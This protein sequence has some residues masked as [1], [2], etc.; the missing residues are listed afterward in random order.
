MIQEKYA[1][2]DTETAMEALGMSSSHDRVA[3]TA[4]K[5]CGTQRSNND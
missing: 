4:L 5:G 2:K 3:A 1:K